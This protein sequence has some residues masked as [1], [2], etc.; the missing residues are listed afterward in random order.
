MH[1]KVLLSIYIYLYIHHLRNI[2]YAALKSI[3]ACAYINLY[4]INIC[5][6]TLYTNSSC[7]VGVMG[8]R[9]RCSILPATGYSVP[10]C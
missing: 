10:L 1:I 2:I 4:Y 3:I 8:T 5:I 6:Q 7:V 9:P